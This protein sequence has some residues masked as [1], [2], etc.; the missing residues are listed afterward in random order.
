MCDNPSLNLNLFESR[1]T[2]VI[3]T[4]LNL[5]D[6]IANSYLNDKEYKWVEGYA[7]RSHGGFVKKLN[8]STNN[9]DHY[10]AYIFPNVTKLEFTK[11]S[12]EQVPYN[13]KISIEGVDNTL[14]FVVEEVKS[15]YQL[16]PIQEPVNETHD[17]DSSISEKNN[18]TE[19]EEKSDESE[20]NPDESELNIDETNN[21]GDIND[22]LTNGG[23]IKL[24]IN[25]KGGKKL[26]KK[27][28]RQTVINI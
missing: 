25:K 27:R 9:E 28:M 22:N 11:I 1:N 21:E 15:K 19:N 23:N 5:T 4:L 6:E 24:K 18:V 16:C 20:L 13:S 8:S 26:T 2:L 7:L 17:N 14:T 3:E 12:E 10:K